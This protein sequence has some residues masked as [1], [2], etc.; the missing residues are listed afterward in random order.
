MY[1]NAGKR[2]M[3]VTSLFTAIVLF[4][5]FSPMSFGE[6]GGRYQ[7]DPWTFGLM[8]DTQWTATD[9]DTYQVTDPEDL[10]PETVSAALAQAIGE[11]FIGHGVKFVIQVGDLSDQAGDAAMYARS[12][13]AQPLTD[14]G[15]GF[16]PLRGNHETYGKLF[17]RD[18]EL[19]M[20]IPAFRDAFQ[21]TRG[22]KDTFGAKNFSSPVVDTDILNGLS[23]S[24]DY[25][26]QTAAARFVIVDVE[27]TSYWEKQPEPHPVYGPG[28]DYPR[29]YVTWVLYKHT[30]EVIA[31][32]GTIIPPGTWFRIASSGFPSTNFYGW[33]AFWPPDT[34]TD[35]Q[36]PKW[37]SE[38]TEFW[39]GDQQDWINDRL[40]INTRGTEHAFVLSHRGLM[41]TNHVDGFFGSSPGSK[42][43]TQIPFYRSLVDNGVRYMLSGHDHLH[44]RALVASPPDKNGMTYQI[45]Q[46]IHMAASTKFYGPEYLNE[47]YGTKSRETQISQDLYNVGYYLYTIAGPRVLV[48]YYADATGN[49]QDG[50]DYPHGNASVRGRLFL[51]DLNF[52][53]KESYGYGINGKQFVVSQGQSYAVVA[54]KFGKTSARILAGKN[55]STTV[56]ET[57]EEY[58]EDTLVSA[59]RPLHKVVT[60]GWVENPDPYKLQSDILSLWGMS[61][62]GMDGETDT[63]VLSMSYDFRTK[64]RNARGGIHL[65]TGL[66]VGITTCVDGE[67][68]N[69]VEENFGGHKKYVVGPYHRK[70]GL[71]TYGVDPSTKT[72]WAVLNYNADFAVADI[73]PEPNGNGPKRK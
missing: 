1:K 69:A 25:G 28:Y 73:E 57:P 42:S 71:G 66:G 14:A 29:N 43:S 62:I 34:M 60:T 9:P 17:G 46:I 13:A 26:N 61:E 64:H 6:G 35:P 23:Y 18:P 45:Q 15:I 47:F 20:D 30:E 65:G 19:D 50:A 16:F 68:V 70:H 44:N 54:D 33:D 63:Y 52:I 39:P 31:E 36:Q 5:A 32:D 56:D 7:G 2:R 72:V 41:G 55:A 58:E 59:P 67:W 11:K 3:A 38:D 10:N 8:A 37:V 22:L 51:P 53:K 49:F 48:D 21:Q 4:F 12:A 40:D 27:A 24:F